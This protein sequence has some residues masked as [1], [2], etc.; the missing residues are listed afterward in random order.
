ML[1]RLSIS[2]LISRKVKGDSV[3]SWLV[4]KSLLEQIF[5]GYNRVVYTI[6]MYNH[7]GPATIELPED[8]HALVTGLERFG[9]G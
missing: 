4:T 1:F 7:L 8:V 9:E 3:P 6:R 5:T 2:S